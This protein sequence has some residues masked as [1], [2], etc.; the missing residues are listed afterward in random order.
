MR[1]IFHILRNTKSMILVFF[2]TLLIIILFGEWKFY[3]KTKISEKNIF[4]VHIYFI[5]IKILKFKIMIKKPKDKFGFDIYRIRKNKPNK[6]IYSFVLTKKKTR[7]KKYDF[8]FLKHTIKIEKLMV[9]IKFGADDAYKTAIY[10]GFFSII[11]GVIFSY[12]NK[13][14]HK[15]KNEYKITP[16]Y[17][18]QVFNIALNCIISFNL[19]NII[20]EYLK[21]KIKKRKRR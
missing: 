15:L 8:R 4:S 14:N 9:E 1:I 21:S 11:Y 19:A 20:I 17:N 3:I 16:N 13:R 5:Y 7:K 18:S 12:F 6:N 10:C 2:F